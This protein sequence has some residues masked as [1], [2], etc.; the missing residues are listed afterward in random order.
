MCREA[1]LTRDPLM[2]TLVVSSTALDPVWS[3]GKS[4]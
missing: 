4:G 2:D 1:S 3:S